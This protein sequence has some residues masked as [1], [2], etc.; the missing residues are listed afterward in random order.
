[1]LADVANDLEEKLIM[2]I[3][4]SSDYLIAPWAFTYQLDLPGQRVLK[5]FA[6]EAHIHSMNWE[7]TSAFL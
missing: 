3:K 1:M 7:F 4:G 5:N 2:N 6:K